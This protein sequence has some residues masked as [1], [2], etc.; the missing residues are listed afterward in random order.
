VPFQAFATADGWIVVACAKEKFWRQLAE[1]IGRP[2]LAADP[3]FSDFAARDANRHELLPI[4]E[5]TF[6]A[7]TTDHWVA[8][9]AAAG[10]PS[11]PVN[12]VAEAL[13][14]PQA[15]AR[16]MVV[17]TDHPRFGTVRQVAGAVRVGPPPQHR[18]APQ[19]NEDADYVLGE[20]LGYDAAR[21]AELAAAG[22]FG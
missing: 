18:R 13:A 12:S 11:G 20:L 2:E 7:A 4:L 22:G 9:L 19:R 10:V 14:D 17:E 5:E 3:R 6:A 16:Q 8:V 21:R 15:V 1:A